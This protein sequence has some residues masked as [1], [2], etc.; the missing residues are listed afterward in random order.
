MLTQ[1]FNG[2]YKYRLFLCEPDKDEI[3]EID[4][5][6]LTYSAFLTSFNELNFVASYYENG[7][8]QVK[9]S[10]YDLLKGLYLIR[11]DIYEDTTLIRSEYMSIIEPTDDFNDGAMIKTLRCYSSHYTT[12]NKKQLVGYEEVKMLYDNVGTDGIIN[13]I[14]IY[15]LLNTWSVGY[16]NS[17]LLNLYHDFNI[18]GSS[19]IDVF[20]QLEK[21]FNCIFQFDNINNLINIYTTDEIGSN[22]GLVLSHDNFMQN[23]SNTKKYDQ[24]VTRLY[25]Y[26][27]DGAVISRYNPTGQLY[28]DD[29]TW[30]INNGYFSANLIS[31]WNAYS[32]LVA[33]ATPSFNIYLSE[34]DT[35]ES[36]LLNAQQEYADLIIQKKQLEDLMDVIKA[37]NYK[38]NAEYDI[39]YS[40]WE[41]ICSY[42]ITKQEEINSIRAM[43]LSKW[44]DIYTLNNSLLY[45]NNFTQLVLEELINFIF[46][47]TLNLDTVDD[48]E[49][50]YAY[51]N[52]YIGVKSQP[53]INI[54]INI[55][56]LFNC[57]EAYEARD[58]IVL[59]DYINI[60]QEQMGFNYTALQL[61][62]YSHNVLGNELS[63][64]FSNT[65]K[66][67]S[68]LYYLNDIFRTGSKALNEINNNK[69]NWDLYN[70]DKNNLIRKATPLDADET[71]IRAGYNYINRRGFMGEDIG[72]FG[73]IQLLKDR[74]IF[75]KDAWETFYTLLSANGLYLENMLENS[76]IVITP[77]NG[78]QIDQ[79]NTDVDDW[80]NV[81]YIGINGE[82]HIDNGYLELQ[83]IVDATPVNKINIDPTYGMKIQKNLTPSVPATPT[84]FSV[85]E[86]NAEGDI[87]LQDEN[88]NGIILDQFGMDTKFIKWFKNMC[89]NSSFEY[90]NND[91]TPKYWTGGISSDGSNFFGSYSLKLEPA[92]N[93]VQSSSGIVNPQWYNDVSTRTRVSFHKK[94]GAVKI[95]VLDGDD[96]DNPLTLTD[97]NGNTG[98]YIEYP[99]NANWVAGSYSVVCTHGA[100][101][102]IKVKFE[103]SDATYDAYIDG[104]IIEPDY[105]GRRPSFYTDGPY[106]SEVIAYIEDGDLNIQAIYV[107]PDEPA[108]AVEDDVWIDDDD[109]SRYDSLSLSGNITLDISDPEVLFATGTITITLHD[110]TQVGVIKKI[111]NTGTGLVTIS[112]SINGSATT[113][114]LY[115]LESLELITDGTTWRF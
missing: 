81:V 70:S 41:V 50:L 18:S 60:Y 104:V 55:V 107:Q 101:T 93:S 97:G 10:N 78:F 73:Q 83:K 6:N 61:V 48:E 110:A 56:D 28:V 94:M 52:Q 11:V 82:F 4:Y 20:K 114:V 22:T 69:S 63:L 27:K 40:Q 7:Y 2:E 5:I 72:S 37:T 57:A 86:L 25:V 12:F 54:N 14:L 71:E 62:S 111:Y 43:I 42:V 53:P 31:E 100:T 51:A 67:E 80:R 9:D 33:S 8:L 16:I 108:E 96:G 34:L 88:G 65:L 36:N 30:F 46:E 15:K 103:N 1:V 75:S 21:D 106:S 85:F 74:I 29:F 91:G 38:N 87:V 76:R 17:S 84:W 102:K 89:Y 32:I 92:E 79:W 109:Y 99:Y 77:D 115:P 24:L 44:D 98:T 95:Y 47:E 112:G 35:L 3:G 45:S 58:R 68:D 26:G 49:Q 19:L 59:G 105:T 90:R 66:L 64:T 113:V 23:I 13:D 39:Y